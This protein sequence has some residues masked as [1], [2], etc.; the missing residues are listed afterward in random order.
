MATTKYINNYCRKYGYKF[1]IE[2]ENGKSWCGQ[3]HG[4]FTVDL[5]DHRRKYPLEMHF[6]CE[7]CL[8]SFRFYHKHWG[9]RKFKYYN[10]RLITRVYNG[11]FWENK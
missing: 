2:K 10:G 9:C 4:N 6:A 3:P 8:E 1:H 5:Y 7:K 11:W